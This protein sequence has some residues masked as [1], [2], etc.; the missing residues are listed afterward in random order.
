MILT[1]SSRAKSRSFIIHPEVKL[2]IRRLS[3]NLMKAAYVRGTSALELNPENVRKHFALKESYLGILAYESLK[4]LQSN[5][6]TRTEDLSVNLVYLSARYLY[7]EA[8]K[9]IQERFV[10]TTKCSC[11]LIC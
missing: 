11:T 4:T 7:V 2:L 10:L 5:R 6:R 9:Q 8:I 1:K 3:I